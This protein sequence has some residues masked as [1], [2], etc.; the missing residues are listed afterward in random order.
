MLSE[1]LTTTTNS[2]SDQTLLFN[3]L[4]FIS[5]ASKSH[6]QD[7][8]LGALLAISQLACR[9]TLTQDYAQAFFKQVL[10]SIT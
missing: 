3:L 4:P 5:Q 1:V 10:L 6:L 7:L 9:R 2:S 8:K